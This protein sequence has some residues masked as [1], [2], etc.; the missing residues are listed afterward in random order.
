M[1]NN[2]TGKYGEW[3]SLINSVKTPLGFLTLI[4]LIL[5][6]IL[7]GIA[8]F[9]DKLSL[10]APLVF[11]GLLVAGVF[12]IIWKKPLVLYHPSDWP[13]QKKNMIIN[14]LF[15]IDA[16]KVNLNIQRCT[17]EVRDLGG[18]SKRTGTPNLT[19]GNGGWSFQLTEDVEPYDSVRLELV[20]H[21]G[22]RWRVN[23][24]SPYEKEVKVLQS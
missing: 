6:G 18:K 7:L 16:Y 1:A 3:A 20:E 4:A 11:L 17:F 19:F 8:A 14:M 24:F 12:A 22:Q 9:T 13:V 2:D 23:P 21:S 5:D 10:W 15:P